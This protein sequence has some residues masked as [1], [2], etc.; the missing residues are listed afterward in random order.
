MAAATRGAHIPHSA[1]FLPQAPRHT[2]MPCAF[3]HIPSART[4]YCY[5]ASL[6]SFA[7][8][9][10]AAPATSYTRGLPTAAGLTV[11]AGHCTPG[12]R[13][14]ACNSWAGKNSAGWASRAAGRTLLEEDF[15]SA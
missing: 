9:P 1:L 7:P 3:H 13:N 2:A 11:S 15:Y 4:M 10:S 14:D 6:N 12:R 5:G 8:L